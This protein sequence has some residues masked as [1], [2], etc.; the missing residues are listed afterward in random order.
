MARVAGLFLL[1]QFLFRFVIARLQ[2]DRISCTNAYGRLSFNDVEA[3]I[4]EA[5]AIASTADK[6]MVNAIAEKTTLAAQRIRLI[7]NTMLACEAPDLW[8]R[9]ARSYYTAVG[10][11]K[12]SEKE[13][14]LFL[15]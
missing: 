15:R 1:C 4:D 12:S 10:D 8:C 13:Y 3:A 6:L 7:T 9:K 14:F 11:I 2:I 5:I